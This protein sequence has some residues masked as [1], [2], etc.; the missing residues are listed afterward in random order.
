MQHHGVEYELCA[1]PTNEAN[2]SFELVFQI[3][4]RLEAFKLNRY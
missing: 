3:A 2:K 4:E 1:L